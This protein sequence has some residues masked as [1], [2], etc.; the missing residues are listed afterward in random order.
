M[1]DPTLNIT[2]KKVELRAKM[3]FRREN[4]LR[5]LTAIQNQLMFR[6]LP[7]PLRQIATEK[8]VI[9]AYVPY[10]GEPDI[11]AP[12]SAFQMQMNGPA[13]I[14]LPYFSE[15]N[16]PMRFRLWQKGEV[17]ERGPYKIPQPLNNAPEVEPN[18]LLMPLLAF[19]RNFNRL[20]QGGGHYDRYLADHDSFKVG[21]AWSVQEVDAL[22]IEATD[23]SLDA[24]ITET[25]WI[26]RT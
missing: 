24:I 18:L 4:F 3:R 19:D 7:S 16:S 13:V 15:R 21:V 6:A 1:A 14:A 8:H 26:I 25:E 23:I 11:L 5:N 9:G 2:Q 20:G 22:P 10:G 12:L 17:L